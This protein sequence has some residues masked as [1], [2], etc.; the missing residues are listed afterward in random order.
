MVW[1]DATKL[2][3][4]AYRQTFTPDFRGDSGAQ[5]VP[6]TDFGVDA[7][8]DTHAVTATLPGGATLRVCNWSVD[9]GFGGLTKVTCTDRA[10]AGLTAGGVPAIPRR[11][12]IVRVS[13]LESEADYVVGRVTAGALK[14]A[15]WRVGQKNF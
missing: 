12:A 15:A 9:I 11:V 1:S 8:T 4:Y 6:T 10:I 2:F 7:V 14:L 13:E 5:A 3:D